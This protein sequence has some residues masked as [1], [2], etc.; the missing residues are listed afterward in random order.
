MEDIF[1]E[2]AAV[3]VEFRETGNKTSM[4]VHGEDD[5]IAEEVFEMPDNVEED[6]EFKRIYGGRT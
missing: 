6:G 5:K 3:L 1:R 2:G 4:E